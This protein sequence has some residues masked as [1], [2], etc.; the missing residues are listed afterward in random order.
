MFHGGTNFWFYEWLFSP[1][2]AIDLPQVTSYDYDALL[3]EAGTQLLNILQWKN[4]MATYYLVSAIRTALQEKY[5]S[6]KHI[7]TGRESLSFRNL[8][9]LTILHGKLLPQENA[10]ELGQG[11]GYLLYRYGRLGVDEERIRNHWTDRDRAQLLS[12]VK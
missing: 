5:G 9:S 12:I 10:K 6:W 1:Q 7:S 2:G 8:D 4:V 11:Y 3:D